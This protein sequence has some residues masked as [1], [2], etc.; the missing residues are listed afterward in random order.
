M[1]KVV[2][3]RVDGEAAFWLN[4]QL[5]SDVEGPE[6]DCSEMIE[7][8]ARML[9]WTLNNTTTEGCELEVID[10]ETPQNP[11]WFWEEFSETLPL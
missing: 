6:A 3:L 2:L 9:A 1:N 10:R 4:G 11:V 8:H 5:F 7:A